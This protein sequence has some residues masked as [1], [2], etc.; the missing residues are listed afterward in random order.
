[1]T[2]LQNF[3]D[4]PI[5]AASAQLQGMNIYL[6]AMSLPGGEKYLTVTVENAGGAELIT[7]GTTGTWII[8]SAEEVRNGVGA[9]T[10][11]DGVVPIVTAKDI[12]V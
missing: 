9:F 5:D 1:M 11:C 3:E 12:P 10:T 6:V 2:T 4:L 8:L 7:D